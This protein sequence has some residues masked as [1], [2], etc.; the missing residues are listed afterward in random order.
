M[1]EY[2]RNMFYVLNLSSESLTKVTC[3][4]GAQWRSGRASDSKLIGPEF[5]SV[6]QQVESN[7]V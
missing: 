5:D 7:W 3:K 2:M 6:V 1:S 4:M